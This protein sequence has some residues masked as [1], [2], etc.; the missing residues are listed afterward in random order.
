MDVLR[1]QALLPA[2]GVLQD[3]RVPYRDACG[4]RRR[5]RGGR[6][7]R[8]AARPGRVAGPGSV[9]GERLDGVGD[10]VDLGDPVDGVRGQAGGARYLD[11][12][13]VRPDAVEAV[14]GS[15]GAVDLE[16][17]GPEVVVHPARA[18]PG[19]GGGLNGL[20]V[21]AGE[22]V[23]LAELLQEGV[24]LLLHG[25]IHAVLGLDP[26]QVDHVLFLRQAGAHR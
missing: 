24:G 15:E 7:V 2:G 3:G 20:N 21:Q 10:A 16:Q 11:G 19:I 25:R 26:H 9:P 23:V 14:G 1:G 13:V 5:G 18:H 4:N 8:F 12:P 17:D 6:G 22:S